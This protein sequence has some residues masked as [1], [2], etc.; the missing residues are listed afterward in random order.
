MLSLTIAA[1][2]LAPFALIAVAI[3]NEWKRGEL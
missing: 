1:L 3:L 2:M